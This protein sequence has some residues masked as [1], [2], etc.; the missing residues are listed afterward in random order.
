MPDSSDSPGW[1]PDPEHRGGQRWWNG[2]G[3]SDARRD[4]PTAGPATGFRPTTAP[5]AIPSSS[6]GP[7]TLGAAPSV[8]PAAPPG[9]PP[10]TAA[11]GTPGWT[12]GGA[13]TGYGAYGAPPTP[14]PPPGAR[15][16][17]GLT[18][19]GGAP[20]PVNPYEPNPYASAPSAGA[21][22]GSPAPVQ[23]YGAA[24]ARRRTN[25]YAIAGFVVSVLGLSSGFGGVIGFALSIAALRRADRMI[26]ENGP[27]GAYRGLAIAG[28]VIGSIGVV[29]AVGTLVARI[30]TAVDGG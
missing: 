20:H 26:R 19:A 21:A 27:A 8:P 12:S 7:P 23:Y 22:P 2:A 6:P 25:G 11:G 17:A 14:P 30:V 16:N 4:A 3:W 29:I 28:V 9:Y 5:P 1:Y 15:L 24:N 13:V 18:A 10:T